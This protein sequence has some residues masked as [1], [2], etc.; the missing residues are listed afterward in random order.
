MNGENAKVTT[1]RYVG[2]VTALSILTLVLLLS[3]V[4]LSVFADA[5][6]HDAMYTG[7]A[8]GHLWKAF[9]ASFGALVG[10]VGGKVM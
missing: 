7:E 3:A 10:Y 4:L 9:W 6:V 2:G 1:A 5:K 8:I